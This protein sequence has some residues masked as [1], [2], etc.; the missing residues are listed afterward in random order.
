MP[1]QLNETKIEAYMRAVAWMSFSKARDEVTEALHLLDTKVKPK[2]KAL[3][4]Q[5]LAV[6]RY[7]RIG[8]SKLH[9]NWSWTEADVRRQYGLEPTRTLYAEATKVQTKFSQANPG[10]RLELTP[11]RSLE[12]QIGLWM[13]N[14]TV[15]LASAQLM[16]DMDR[17]LSKPDY[18]D[19]S[20]G[21]A[22]SKFAGKLRSAVVTPEPTSAAPGASDHGR[23][24]AVDFIIMQGAS[25]I[26]GTAKVEIGPVWDSK[27]WS[28]KLRAAVAGTKLRGPLKAPY[29]PWHWYL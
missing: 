15:Q 5:L 6:R 29:E 10:Y 20:G 18:P 24:T 26:A 28:T 17:E 2:G 13:D 11:V 3:P 19:S 8:D 7:L 22:V 9:A 23:G 14:S 16:T 4:F 1:Q 12:R 25:R 27:G 21:T